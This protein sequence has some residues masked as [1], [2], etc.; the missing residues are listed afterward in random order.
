MLVRDL[1]AALKLAPP[2][3][4]VEGFNASDEQGEFP[5]HL[6]THHL[7]TNTV[8]LCADPDEYSVGETVLHRDL[9]EAEA[10]FGV[11]R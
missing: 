1:I 7:R 8:L 2:N 4:K 10:I 9:T 5:I 6:V 3:A 11:G